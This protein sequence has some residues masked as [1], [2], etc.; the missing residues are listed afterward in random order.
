MSA[1]YSFHMTSRPRD[2]GPRT[3]P[4]D[5]KAHTRKDDI[6]IRVRRSSDT[7]HDRTRHA[8][9]RHRWVTGSFGEAPSVASSSLFEASQFACVLVVLAARWKIDS[10]V[11]QLTLNLSSQFLS[12]LRHNVPKESGILRND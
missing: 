8:R 3:A 4:D 7:D 6:F 10:G 1:T 12:G 11:P 5:R 9:V 2:A